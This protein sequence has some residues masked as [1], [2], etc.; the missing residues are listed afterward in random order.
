MGAVIHG[1]L[2]IIFGALSGLLTFLTLLVKVFTDGRDHRWSLKQLAEGNQTVLEAVAEGTAISTNA[3][4]YA[5]HL[6]Q[7]LVKAAVSIPPVSVA[8]AVKNLKNVET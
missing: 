2:V 7:R 5:N 3:L 6:T 4:E 1:N 8:D